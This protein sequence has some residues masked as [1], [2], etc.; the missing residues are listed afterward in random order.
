MT[1]PRNGKT[2]AAFST[3]WKNIFNG[4]ERR[5]AAAHT[6]NPSFQGTP[7]REEKT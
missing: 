6:H 2:F 1:F 3:P 4:G 5:G 7:Q